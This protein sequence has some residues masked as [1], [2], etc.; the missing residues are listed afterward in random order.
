MVVQSMATQV[1]FAVDGARQWRQTLS[2]RIQSESAVRLY[3][4]LTFGY[5]SESEQVTVDYVRVR[6]PDGSVIDTP[7]SSIQDLTTETA[8][9]APTYSDLRQKQIPVKALGVGDVLE[10]SISSSQK[11]PEVPGQFW[12]SQYFA[13][14]AVILNQTL[15]IRV[16]AGKYVQISSPKLKPETHDEGGQRVYLWKY[17]H[18]EISKPDDKKNTESEDD[19]PKVQLTTF[20]NWEEVGDWWAG[21]ASP[22]AAVTPEIEKKAHELTAGVSS[23][24]EKARAIYSYVATKF[25]YISISFGAGRYRPHSAREI[26]SNQYGDCKDKHTLFAALLKAAGIQAWPALI[27]A[28]LKF[29]ETLP[30]PSQFNHVITVLPQNGQFL[31]LDTTAEVAPFAL[32]EPSIRDETA[33]V[34]PNTGAGKPSLLKT[35][36]DPPFK[37]SDSVFVKASLAADG[38]LTGHFDLHM[39]GDNGLLLRAGFRQLA[40]AQWQALAQQIAY[41]MGY[42]GD[43][44]GVEVENL[45]NIDKSFH[46][47]YD[48]NR[49]NY[50]DWQEHKITVPIPPLGFGPGAEAEKPKEAFWTGTPGVSNYRASLQIPQG[51]SIELLHG[52]TL[53]S[54]FADYN[55]HYSIESGALVA[56]RKLFI[57]KSKVTLD[58]W[59]AYKKFIK[60][61]QDDQ[62]TFFTLSEIDSIDSAKRPRLR[63]RSTPESD[64]DASDGASEAE[65]LLKR[66]GVAFQ[67][68]RRNEAHDLLVKAEGIDPKAPQLWEM[69]GFLAMLSGKPDEAIDDCRKEIR[70]HPEEIPVYGE[71]VGILVHAG[72]RDDAIAVWR[73]ALAIAP[74][75]EIAAAGIAD[76]LIAAK[77]YAEVPP[78]LEKPIAAA[79]KN[80]WLQLL[81][82]NALLHAGQKEQGLA[83]AQKIIAASPEPFNLN[84]LAFSLADTSTA[85]DLAQQW[86]QKAVAQTEQ[87]YSKAELAGFEPKDLAAV[88]SLAAYWD[89]A[90]WVYFKQGDLKNAEKYITAA[91]QLGQRAEL[92]DHLGQIYEKQGRHADAI[93]LWRLAIASSADYAGAKEQLRKAGAAVS[94]PTPRTRK[95]ALSFIPPGEELGKLRTIPIPAL[96]KQEGSAEF[97]VLISSAGIE[98][99]QF[100]ESTSSL[101]GTQELAHALRAVDYQFPFP[102]SGSEKIIRR[103]ILSCSTYTTPSCQFTMLLQSDVLTRAAR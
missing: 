2:V 6:K 66:A 9:A 67:S 4:V 40:P 61:V 44:S 19:T 10:Y 39:E 79:P 12:Y 35:P 16:A 93:H 76:L 29:D 38:T 63:H 59:E 72:K 71:L 82:A 65:E 100:I 75:N 51:F 89:T 90:G 34:I 46:Y 74:Q 36:A 43:V 80:Y 5:E 1:S 11:T 53:T 18:L 52:A 17:S 56:E 73:S 78:I 60:G 85:L 33:L 14:D 25:R 99:A 22:Q 15:E 26:L 97:F 49:K 13:K 95:A 8:A 50:S 101:K 62:I 42:A 37:T 57:K 45:E 54:D 84:E 81:R 64:S 91:W 23:D 92:A 47:S 70:L 87:Q 55:S 48:Y 30:L 103:G 20:K 3:G 77:R 27:G 94:E 31:W 98:D 69:Y 28:G 88:N 7:Q 102:D 96:P 32:L 21:L 41:S 58:Q 86:A 24:L 68:G 83:E